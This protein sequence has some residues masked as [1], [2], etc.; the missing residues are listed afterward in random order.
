[1]GI[2][3]MA[4]WI[5]FTPEPELVRTAAE[6]LVMLSPYANLLQNCEVVVELE[7][8]EGTKRY[9]A[10]VF[11]STGSVQDEGPVRTSALEPIDALRGAFEAAKG[12]LENML[13]NRR[14]SP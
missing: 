13:R 4:K 14:S 6:Y 10:C 7:D 1:M 5:G 9:R 12:Q 3:M 11:L 8:E 2:G